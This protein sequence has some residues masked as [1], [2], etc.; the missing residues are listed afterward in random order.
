MSHI[1]EEVGFLDSDIYKKDGYIFH[2]LYCISVKY[3]NS[4]YGSIKSPYTITALQHTDI[5]IK[6]SRISLWQFLK[7]GV[8][9]NISKQIMIAVI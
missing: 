6:F 3:E 5:Y 4:S 7:P 2:S 1:S 8:R 9:Y